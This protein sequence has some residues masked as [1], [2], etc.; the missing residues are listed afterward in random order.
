[1]Y[2]SKDN[3]IASGFVSE[4][5]LTIV[6]RNSMRL[7]KTGGARERRQM[8]FDLGMFEFG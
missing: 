1:M 8:K 7:S 3:S 5:Q 2:T 4:Q 6:V